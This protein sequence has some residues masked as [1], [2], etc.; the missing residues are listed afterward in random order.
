MEKEAGAR[1]SKNSK[2]SESTKPGTIVAGPDAHAR[3]GAG[4]TPPGRSV[5]PADAQAKAS[6]DGKAD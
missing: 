4:K 3:E 1:T 6:T 5:K 2:R